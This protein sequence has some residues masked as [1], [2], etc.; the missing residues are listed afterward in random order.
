[1]LNEDRD[2]NTVGTAQQ[3]IKKLLHPLGLEVIQ[4]R[5]DTLGVNP[6]SDIKTFV[7]H[8]NR[9]VVFDVGANIG[10]SVRNFKMCL[11]SSVI[12]LL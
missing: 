5:Q 9:P 12:Q 6:F 10:Q 1:M 3:I 2:R 8:Y 11:P 4:Y 7:G